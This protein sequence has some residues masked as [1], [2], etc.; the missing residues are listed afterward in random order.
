MEVRKAQEAKQLRKRE[1]EVEEAGGGSESEQRDAEAA[2][3]KKRM[4]I[5]NQRADADWL[6][7]QYAASERR[8]AG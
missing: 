3:R 8:V 7:L 2:H 4:E 5:V 1:H 6:R